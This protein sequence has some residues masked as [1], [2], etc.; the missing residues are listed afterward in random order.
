MGI[1]NATPDSFFEGSRVESDEA[2]LS[3][4]RKMIAEGAEILD[5][6]GYS[7]RPGADDVSLHEEI[8]RV[9]LAIQTIRTEFSDILISVDT[10]RAEVAKAGFEAGADIVNDISGGKLDDQ[11][12]QTVAELKMPYIMM[13]MKGTPQSMSTETAYTH[14]LKDINYYFSEQIFK[15]RQTGIK[16]IIIDPGFG[17][18]K[19][20]EQNF[21]LLQ[22]LDLLQLHDCPILV[23][24]SRKSMI[25]KSLGTTAQEALNGTSVL[26]GY[27]LEKGAMILRVHDVKEAVEAVQLHSLIHCAE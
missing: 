7:S 23:G 26:N 11:M 9:Q 1:I 4:A 13:H 24:I 15:A 8:E 14:L 18:A 10:F 17:F 5:I 3:T 12:F 20:I 27:A 2:V 6:G 21:E 25:Y 22:K 16:D 19:T